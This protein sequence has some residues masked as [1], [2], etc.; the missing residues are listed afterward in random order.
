M[1]VTG[2]LWEVRKM[3]NKLTL[4]EVIEGAIQ[5]EIMS[6][7]LYIGLRQRVKKQASR[8]IFQ[9]LAEQEEVHQRILQDFLRGLYKEGSLNFGLV[10]D[11]KIAEYLDQP[12]ISPTMD[13]VEVFLLAA[14]KEKLAH[15]LYISLSEIYPNGQMK[16]LLEDL[17]DQEL[18]HKNRLESL[19]SE[20]TSS[21][22]AENNNKLPNSGNN[23]K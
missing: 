19:Y 4:K 9:A 1:S 21:Q 17:A 12:E 6:R 16:H 3:D 15:D 14:N 20:V 18:E 2:G 7:F 5:K 23:S 22:K 10:V 8:D 11:S 13:I